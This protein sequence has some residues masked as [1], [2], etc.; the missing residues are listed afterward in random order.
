MKLRRLELTNFRRHRHTV[1]DVPDGVTAITGPNGSGKSTLLEAVGFA[2]YGPRASRTARDLVRS[3]DAPVGDAVVVALEFELAG[4]AWRIVRQL[5]GRSQSPVASVEVD[6]VLEVQPMAGSSEAATHL[7]E[8]TLGLDRDGF[9]HTVVA[10][11][12]EVDRLARLPAPE[13]RSFILE[14]AGVGAVDVAVARARE[15]RNAVRAQLEEARRTASD[16]AV[17]EASVAEAEWALEAASLYV[18]QAQLHAESARAALEG[19]RA[20]V[21]ALREAAHRRAT[22]EAVAAA[23]RRRW[24]ECT[25]EALLWER[26]FAASGDAAGR[27]AAAAPDAKA[28]P[29]LLLRSQEVARAR[30]ASRLALASRRNLDAALAA[31]AS[32][33]AAQAAWPALSPGPDVGQAEGVQVAAL[34]ARD[35]ALGEVVRAGE[36]LRV[37]QE[38]VALLGGLAAGSPCPQCGQPVTKGHLEASHEAAVAKVER[39]KAEVGVAQSSRERAHAVFD[40]RSRELEAARRAERLLSE[41]VRR[42][43]EE[44]DRAAEE[45]RRLEGERALLPPESVVEADGLEEALERARRAHEEVLKSGAEAAALA[46][47]E[48]LWQEA[49]KATDA[50]ACER[51]A[52][53]VAL[54]AEPDALVRLQTAV[55]ATEAARGV[56]AEADAGRLRALVAEGAARQ[57]VAL[58]HERLGKARE[59]RERVLCLEGELARWVAL[60]GLSGDGLLD[61]FRD[62]LVE[63]TAPAVAWE[64]SRLLSLFT[65]GRYEE[66]ILTPEYEILVR[67]GAT[68]FPIERFSGGERDLVHLALRLATSRLVARRAAGAEIRW[69]ALDEVFSSLDAPHRALVARA[70]HNLGT[71]YGQILAVTHHEDLQEALDAA[72]RLR[73]EGLEARVENPLETVAP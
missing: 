25:R 68:T 2:L 53:D 64:A 14:L 47:R 67:D 69:V 33:E 72:V 8:K 17:A 60:V 55:A 9:F 38:Q 12:G 37:A 42:R 41:E 11:Q 49:A 35:V 1:W 71:L 27:V 5:R 66:V 40:V 31:L 70:L 16:V 63:R 50:A 58:A 22:L 19:A 4:Q 61:R 18:A 62:H 7:V 65:A 43:R 32:R 51:A 46:E 24:E 45:R 28:W 30:E 15:R 29:A 57:A 21:A 54:A 44:V 48:R 39:A 34:R 6:G 56:A 20:T 10:Q 26:A 73:L 59:V 13:R 52:A 23:A 36:A 3:A